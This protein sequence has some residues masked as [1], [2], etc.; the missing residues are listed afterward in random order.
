M[1]KISGAGVR[2][3]GTCVFAIVALYAGTA[4]QAAGSPAEQKCQQRRYAA[5]AKF[6]ACEHKAIGASGFDDFSTSSVS[7][8]SKCRLKYA[9]TWP[10]IQDAAAGTGTSCDQAR[11][12]TVA[13]TVVDHLTGL[14]WEQKT[15]DGGIH[16]VD[17]RYTW[18][19]SALTAGDGT[20][21]TTF[22]PV[23]NSAPCFA[24]HCDWRL[25]TRAELETL[26]TE[27][28]PCTTVPCIDQNV[29]GPTATEDFYWTSTPDA[30]ETDGA[31][32][33]SFGNGFVNDDFV[34][35]GDF[36]RA[37]RGGL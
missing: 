22:M 11:F 2:P 33:V 24:D 31:W 12:A 20:V 29:F 32:G 16:D 3:L 23:L 28:F 35:S 13:G 36:V 14:Q 10:K 7:A 27:A 1:R 6:V 21:F 26:V 9:A 8:L 18:S 34:D 37:V 25:P 5:A 17:D 19:E 30:V 4:A 15:D